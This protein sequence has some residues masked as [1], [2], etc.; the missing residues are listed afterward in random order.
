MKDYM[1]SLD[2][3]YIMD[4]VSLW[5][6][7]GKS[8]NYSIMLVVYDFEDHSHFPVYFCSRKDAERFCENIISESKC[9]VVESYD[10]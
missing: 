2:I 10:L 4:L 8:E 3:S 7:R 6:G 5:I 9:K 1:L